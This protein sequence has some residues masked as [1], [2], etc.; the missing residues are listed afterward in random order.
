MLFNRDDMRSD[1]PS[2]VAPAPSIAGVSRRWN[3]S[4]TPAGQTGLPGLFA[5]FLDFAVF[6]M[7]VIEEIF[8]P[9]PAFPGRNR[10]DIG[11][12]FRGISSNIVKT[13][14]S[15]NW[16]VPHT[17][18]SRTSMVL[19][20]PAVPDIGVSCPAGRLP[21][22]MSSRPAIPVGDFGSDGASG[23]ES[24]HAVRGM[25]GPHRVS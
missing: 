1:G 16:V 4:H 14:G 3:R 22:V 17:M 21:R 5:G 9:S 15:L 10:A 6:D 7:H 12:E 11:G 25:G 24:T 23:S 13:P 19:P 18:N 8:C 2:A 20:Q